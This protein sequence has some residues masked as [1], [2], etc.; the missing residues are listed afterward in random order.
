[1]RPISKRAS[2]RLLVGPYNSQLVVSPQPE[3][4]T[5]ARVARCTNLRYTMTAMLRRREPTRHRATEADPPARIPLL[6]EVKFLK[7]NFRRGC[8]VAQRRGRAEPQ[9]GEALTQ[10]MIDD[11]RREM[12][13][14]VGR[15]RL[16]T[17]SGM[18]VSSKRTIG[19]RLIHACKGTQIRMTRDSRPIHGCRRGATQGMPM[20]T[21]KKTLQPTAV[22]SNTNLAKRAT[23]RPT[24]LGRP[25]M[26]A[27][28]AARMVSAAGDGFSAAARRRLR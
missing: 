26:R 24:R 17:P 11:N 14:G 18:T 23:T 1:M 15:K 13:P 4:L 27:S 28:G 7:R 12:A 6:L 10:M 2:V 21:A 20:T 9:E 3:F 22:T 8:K 19:A 16:T 25:R 5:W